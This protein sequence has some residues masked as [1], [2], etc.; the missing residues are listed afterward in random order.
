MC[1][2]EIEG[3]VFQYEIQDYANYVGRL[4]VFE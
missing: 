2:H 1:V 3:A 4:A